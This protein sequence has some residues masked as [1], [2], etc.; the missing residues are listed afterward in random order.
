MGNKQRGH[1]CYGC[2]RNRANEKFSEKGHRQHICKECKKAGIDK[3]ENTSPPEKHSEHYY[4]KRIKNMLHL[5]HGNGSVLLFEYENGK[6]IMNTEP[7]FEIV[8]YQPRLE[9]PFLKADEFEESSNIRNTLLLKQEGCT[10]MES[11]EYLD[12]Y[13]GLEGIESPIS[14]KQKRSIDVVLAIENGFLR[15]YFPRN[16]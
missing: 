9:P 11:M 14:K 10:Y 13:K 8:Q 5:F 4:M 15:D 6:Y 7:N 2:G 16:V 1:Y 12:S 3:I